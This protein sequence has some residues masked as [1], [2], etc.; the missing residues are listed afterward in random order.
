MPCYAIH[1]KAGKQIGHVCGKLGKHCAD[2][3]GVSGFLCDFPVGKG[4]TCDRPMCE[5]HACEIGP[6]L[7]YCSTHEIEW[8][9]F[10]ENGGFKEV[11]SNVVP[12]ARKPS[13]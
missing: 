10:R 3:A 5:R 4:K 8:L 11:L 2:C 12:Y 6:D 7:H 13:R 1:D 9:A